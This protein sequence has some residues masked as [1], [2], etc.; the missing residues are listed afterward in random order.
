MVSASGATAEASVGAACG[1]AAGTGAAGRSNTGIIEHGP[2]ALAAR[3]TTG[4]RSGVRARRAPADCRT[5]RP[6]SSTTAAVMRPEPDP[7]AAMFAGYLLIS[8][9]LLGGRRSGLTLGL[10]RENALDHD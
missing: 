1:K 5:G 10:V 6:D 7:A 3:A 8:T 4:P 2:G 9:S